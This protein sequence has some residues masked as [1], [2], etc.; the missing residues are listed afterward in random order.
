MQAIALYFTKN[1]GKGHFLQVYQEERIH[2]KE[3]RSHNE[4]N[5]NHA[6]HLFCHFFY[7]QFLEKSAI[8]CFNRFII[9]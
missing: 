3:M 9:L 4:L 1:N 8:F 5:R 7:L 2:V 6:I